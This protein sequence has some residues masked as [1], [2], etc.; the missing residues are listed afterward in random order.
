MR[1]TALQCNVCSVRVETRRFAKTVRLLRVWLSMRCVVV[2]NSH[3]ALELTNWFCP[4]ESLN[5]YTQIHRKTPFELTLTV[6]RTFV[7]L[8][9]A[10]HFRSHSL[11]KT[12]PRLLISIERAVALVPSSLTNTAQEHLSY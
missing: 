3:Y 4:V 9:Y 2:E 8:S 7:S 12:I 5:F 11:V 1:M 6:T 10:F